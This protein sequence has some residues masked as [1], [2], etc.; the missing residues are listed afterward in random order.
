[1]SQLTCDNQ[2]IETVAS[3]L[4]CVCRCFFI[5][6]YM[7][8]VFRDD[9]MIMELSQK[10]KIDIPDAVLHYFGIPQLLHKLLGA[11]SKRFWYQF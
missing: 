10:C 6:E 3:Y 8:F 5:E 7:P 9:S 11:L 4:V 2:R 1:M